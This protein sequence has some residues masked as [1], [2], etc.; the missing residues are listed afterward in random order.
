M[1][2]EE[3]KFTNIDSFIKAMYQLS[4][5]TNP[6]KYIED[7]NKLGSIKEDVINKYFDMYV[8]I[9]KKCPHIKI[10]AE[11]RIKTLPSYLEK[12]YKKEKEI[13]RLKQEDDVM[14]YDMSAFRMIVVSII[15][16][17]E[18]VTSMQ[19]NKT[20]KLEYFY[21]IKEKDRQNPGQTTIIIKKINVGDTIHIN[22]VTTIRVTPDNLLTMSDGATC[23]KNE[24]G[25]LF[26]LNGRK[27][28]KDD[29]SSTM[30]AVYELRDAVEEYTKENGY[31]YIP[32]RDKDRIAHPK[33]KA[34]SHIF[35][36]SRYTKEFIIN[37][38]L[39]LEKN[40]FML[41]DE[42]LTQKVM[43]EIQKHEKT[44]ALKKLREERLRFLKEHPE[45]RKYQR[46]A[47]LPEY[48]SYH[49]GY[50]DPITG[51]PFEIQL[52]SLHM[53]RV[54]EHHPLIGHNTY[55]KLEIDDIAPLRVPFTFVFKKSYTDNGQ[56]LFEKTYI[57]DDVLYKKMY[58]KTKEEVFSEIARK[59]IPRVSLAKFPKPVK[60]ETQQPEDPE[61]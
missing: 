31:Q 35:K 30:K 21:R 29:R 3:Y 43:D 12:V 7:Y 1:N 27:I 4:F 40:K 56:L 49:L 54:A 11:G 44:D 16:S 18:Q 39:E 46:D 53:H 36:S 45:K 10:S 58:G 38:L 28:E 32:L 22:E 24:F 47:Y 9:S 50:F 48:Q 26:T 14:I 8:A 6:G 51:Y 17:L 37:L 19:N 41:M 60:Q 52:R 5:D 42:T 57:D 55:K 2:E 25:D 13:L 15:H 23:I 59:K 20:G 61:H 33:T 34:E